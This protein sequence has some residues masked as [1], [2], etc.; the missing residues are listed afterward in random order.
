MRRF[1]PQIA[2]AGVLLLML[3]FGLLR[4]PAPSQA[5]PQNAIYEMVNAA[6]TGDVKRYLASFTGPLNDNL[7]RSLAES[8]ESSFAKYLRDSNAAIKGIAVADPEGV[9]PQQVKAR[10]EYIYQ[11]R[12]QSQ[13]MYLDRS[14][15]GW[16]ISR[17]DN[18]QQ[19]KALIPYGTPI[20]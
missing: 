5:D 18:D 19:T 13:I 20:R 15:Q 17:L 7:R 12:N 2:T 3:V 4:K 11:D 9:T 1:T 10:V 16:K 14:R 6:Q 8:T